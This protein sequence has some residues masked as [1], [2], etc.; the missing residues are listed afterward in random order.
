MKEA[1]FKS[2]NGLDTVHY[3]YTKPENIKGVFIAV[4]GMSE[5]IGRYKELAQMLLSHDIAFFGADNLAHG[6]TAE[7]G[8]HGIFRDNK[9]SDYIVEDVKQLL[10]IAKSHYPLSKVVLFGHSMG[11]FIVRCFASRYSHKIDGLILC[12][13]AK[14][15]PLAPVGNILGNIIKLFKGGEYR[16][17]LLADLAFK[18]YNKKYDNPKTQYD[19]LSRD[20]DEVQKYIDDPLCGFTFSVDGMRVVTDLLTLANSDNCIKWTR[21]DLPILIISGDM[22]PVGDFR[23]GFERVYIEFKSSKHNV[24]MKIYPGARHELLNETNKEEVKSD[25]LHFSQVIYGVI[26][27][28]EGILLLEE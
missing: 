9:Q 5:H 11:S 25:I 10:D 8:K 6:K 24:D 16:S 7:E 19:W 20:E 26:E 12:G 18:Q 13:T 21:K 4:H 3:I 27:D 23:K 14:S 28:D 1:T 17:N 22:D 15:N 2:S